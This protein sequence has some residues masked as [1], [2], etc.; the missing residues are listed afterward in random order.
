MAESMSQGWTRR[1]LPKTWAF[2]GIS[3]RDLRCS[4]AMNLVDSGVSEE[5]VMKIVG[6]KTKAMVSRYNVAN[7]DR[8]RTAMIKDRRHLEKIERVAEQSD[9][10]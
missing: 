10:R 1:P 3:I 5:L 8:L 2:D 6:W 9:T 4:T 7:K